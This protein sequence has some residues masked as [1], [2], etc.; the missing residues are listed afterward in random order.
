M[1]YLDEDAVSNFVDS[2][3][4]ESKYCTDIIKKHFNKKLV[5]TKEDDDDFENSKKCCIRDNFYVDGDVNV[6]SN[7][8]HITGN[9]RSSSH[10]NRN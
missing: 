9:Y 1:S 2:M 6:V 10:R 8:C 7:H 5:K 4:E 3:I